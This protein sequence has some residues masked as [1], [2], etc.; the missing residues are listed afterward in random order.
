[1]KIR[2]TRTPPAEFSAYVE[3]EET[4]NLS[5]VEAR[6][7]I[8]LGFAA[9]VRESENASTQHVS[10]RTE[11]VGADN[12]TE[13]VVTGRGANI[14][15]ISDPSKVTLPRTGTVENPVTDELRLAASKEAATGLVK[16]EAGRTGGFVDETEAAL[17]TAK[18]GEKQ[19]SDAAKAEAKERE[20]VAKKA[21]AKAPENK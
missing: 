10:S 6:Y 11:I 4:S 20:A 18:D 21:Q 5:E 17:P 19:M 13:V 12:Q 3:G 16:Q 9:Q 8:G 14:K 1:M 7:L 15:T 2:F